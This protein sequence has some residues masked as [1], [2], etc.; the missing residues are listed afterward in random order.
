MSLN[1]QEGKPLSEKKKKK[2]SQI[3]LVIM[4]N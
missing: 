1:M 3:K 4:F 2:K